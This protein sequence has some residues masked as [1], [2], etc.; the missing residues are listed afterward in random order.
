MSMIRATGCT[1]GAV[2]LLLIAISLIT[3]KTPNVSASKGAVGVTAA[4][5]GKLLNKEQMADLNGAKGKRVGIYAA[6][7]D[8]PQKG[9]GAIIRAALKGKNSPPL[10]HLYVL[11]NL[12]QEAGDPQ[13]STFY[14]AGVIEREAMVKAMVDGLPVTTVSTF[15]YCHDFVVG[16]LAQN[17]T[18]TQEFSGRPAGASKP[19]S[20]ANKVSLTLVPSEES[21]QAAKATNHSGDTLTCDDCTLYPFDQLQKMLASPSARDGEAYLAPKVQ[22]MLARRPIYRSLPPDYEQLQQQLFAHTVKVM[23]EQMPQKLRSKMAAGTLTVKNPTLGGVPP[24]SYHTQQSAFAVG[25]RLLSWALVAAQPQDDGT[26]A[27]A[28]LGALHSF[29]QG[30]YEWVDYPQ[31]PYLQ[32][33]AAWTQLPDQTAATLKIRPIKLAS[34][35]HEASEYTMN[36]PSYNDG[37][38][39]EPLLTYAGATP[40]IYVHAGN[41]DQALSFHASDGVSTFF[42][43]Y[44][45]SDQR[46][47][48]LFLGKGKNGVGRLI[49]TNVFG[50][51]RL[52]HVLMQIAAAYKAQQVTYVEHPS[53]EPYIALTSSGKQLNVTAQDIAFLGFRYKVQDNFAPIFGATFSDYAVLRTNAWTGNIAHATPIG[54]MTLQG[55]NIFATRNEF[56]DESYQIIEHLYQRGVRK[57]IYLG[58][59]G[60]VNE[61]VRLGAIMLPSAI[62]YEGTT[63]PI[64]NVLLGPDLAQ[65]LSDSRFVAKSHH[66]WV[67]AVLSETTA[68]LKSQQKSGVDAI[69]IEGKYMAEFARLHGDV[70]L[71]MAYVISDHT[72]GQITLEQYDDAS[73]DTVNSSSNFLVQI[74]AKQL[75]WLRL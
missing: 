51:D 20:A 53:S 32:A 40:T 54:V 55:H 26:S 17:A 12:D 36:I 50:K 8:P 65:S 1:G 34:Y 21:P 29:M 25:E 48:R 72:L 11:L 2:S 27:A 30:W 39:P 73:L 44:S 42:E 16:T 4:A 6:R 22:D 62:S 18:L 66:G 28:T 59:A 47:R 74:L 5:C 31:V 68:F 69:D 33:F 70:K 56:G 13:G 61:S 75:P 57:F 43:V 7:F 41:P 58:T 38:F 64:S 52:Q 19:D 63:F 67:P 3:C 15:S 45:R 14:T 49:L 9:H 37:N 10:D 60:A 23:L 71:G 46:H 35:A 24:P